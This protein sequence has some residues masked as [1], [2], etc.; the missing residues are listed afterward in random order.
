VTAPRELL[1][2][3]GLSAKKSWGQNFL[4]DPLVHERIANAAR[5]GVDD[6]VIE[7]GAGLGTLTTVLAARAGRVVAVERDRELAAVLQKELGSDE[8]VRLLE[9][10]ALTLD[11]AALAAEAGRQLVVVGNLPYQIASQLLIGLIAGRA[12][13]AR[14]VVMLQLEMAQRVASQPSTSDYGALTV[15]LATYAKVELCFKVGRGAFLPA[16]RVDSAIVRLTPL[17]APR[18]PIAE[19]APEHY[20]RVVRAA[21]GK[22][23]KTLRNALRDRF[24]DEALDRALA[25][26]GIDG[27]RRGETLAIEEFG[28]L[29]EALHVEAGAHA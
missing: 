10:N 29:A 6:C 25:R 2:K 15:A 28:A 4:C 11:Y 24:A 8:R 13:I 20:E 9:A 26:A 12:H 16:P 23:R 19:Q 18:V 7:I 5:L 17:P 22:R 27:A 1:R 3:Y 21:F 14:A